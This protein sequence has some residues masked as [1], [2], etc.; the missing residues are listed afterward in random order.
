MFFAERNGL[1]QSIYILTSE[2]NFLRYITIMIVVNLFVEIFFSF[3][4]CTMHMYNND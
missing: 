2:T 3:D 4:D 1:K